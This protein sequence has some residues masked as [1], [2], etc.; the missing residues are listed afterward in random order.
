MRIGQA[1]LMIAVVVAPCTCL[2]L[3]GAQLQHVWL[4]KMFETFALRVRTRSTNR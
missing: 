2:H 3:L 4:L 1:L